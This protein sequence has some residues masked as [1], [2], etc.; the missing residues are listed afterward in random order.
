MS[1]NTCPRCGAAISA[2]QH[3][4]PNC[5][6][7][8]AEGDH[9]AAGQAARLGAQP[10]ASQPTP[11]Y[12]AGS[13]AQPGSA[14]MTPSGPPPAYP[15]AAQSYPVPGQPVY[16]NMPPGAYPVAAPRG[17]GGSKALLIVLA[18]VL[19]VVGSCVVGGYLFV[20]RTVA[21][22]T[23]GIST[24]ISSD[25]ISTEV[26]Q[27]GDGTPIAGVTSAPIDRPLTTAPRSFTY[28]GLQ[29]TVV[30]GVISNSV[31]FGPAITNDAS[32]HLDLN[33]SINNPT[34]ASIYVPSA[35]LQVTLGDGRVLKQPVD[36]G[37][38]EQDTQAQTLSFTVPVT[39]T[40]SGARLTFSQ[41]GDEP[42]GLPLDGAAAAATYPLALPASGSA[43]IADQAMT[44]K[45]ISATLDLDSFGK[46]VPS[47]QRYLN[48]TVEVGCQNTHACYVGSGNFRLL[49][50]GQSQAAAQ[51]DPVADAVGSDA[52]EDVRLAFLVAPAIQSAVLQVGDPASGGTGQ[53][54][55]DLSAAP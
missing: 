33:L 13:P 17:G 8:I 40:W 20:S 49:V 2:G 28:A 37:V 51:I 31:P 16:P 48:L 4:C 23:G 39:T 14:P 15:G 41:L 38:Q 5:G 9:D 42:A 22:I 19:V 25:G 50:G 34:A 30:S 1:S 26:A 43:S 10:P 3:F 44:Y 24:A 21:G 46:R 7:A 52:Q 53:I 12:G 47:R 27:F 32:T 18:I 55:L 36:V 54:Q 11:A 6:S 35:L 29:F 45:V